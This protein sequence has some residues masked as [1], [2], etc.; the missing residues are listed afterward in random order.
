[1]SKKI[2]H[3]DIM[4]MEKYQIIR[5][6]KRK[7]IVELK[8]NRRIQIGPHASAHFENFETMLAQVHEMLYIEKG[9]YSQITEELEAYNPLIPNG[10]SLVVTI[11]FEI[12]NPTKRKLFLSKI[13]GVEDT[14]FM[15]LGK[16]RVIGVSEKDVDRTSGDGKASSVQF[17]H[18]YFNRDQI[19]CFKENKEEIFLGISHPEYYHMSKLKK[20]N[21]DSIKND[22]ENY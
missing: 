11:L 12:D 6:E 2:T 20:E 3:E 8:K 15:I 4:D 13:G 9:G 16:E 7:Q 18:F 5:K 21:I 19:N 22:F 1:M 17:I 14:C 10:N